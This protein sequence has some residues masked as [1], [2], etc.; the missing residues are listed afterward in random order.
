MGYALIK[1]WVR[2]G[3]WEATLSMCQGNVPQQTYNKGSRLLR[4]DRHIDSEDVRIWQ[5]E[6]GWRAHEEKDY[7]R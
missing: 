4:I 6:S 5:L 1:I 3:Y 7:L 2:Y